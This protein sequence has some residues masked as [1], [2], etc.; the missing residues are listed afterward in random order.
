MRP[1]ILI[2]YNKPVLPLD[3]PDAGSEHDIIDTA[4]NTAH[5]LKAAGFDVGQLGINYDP[6]PLLDEV[7]LNRP[8]AVFNLFE[9]LATQTGTEV[10]VAALLEWLN[11]PFTGSPSASLA[12][13]RDKVRTKHL[14]A[15]AD[16]P[17]AGPAMAT[18]LACDCQAGLSGRQCRD[19]SGEC[20][21][22]AGPTR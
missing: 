8:A 7:R 10:S 20:R 19:R 6:R 16:L 13:G 18:A 1:R 15:A 4:A 17:N 12:L 9:G 2:L 11:L 14:L 22:L 21:D 5:V 3:H